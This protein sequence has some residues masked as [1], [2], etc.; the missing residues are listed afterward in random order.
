MVGNGVAERAILILL[1]RFYCLRTALNY[2]ILSSTVL[3]CT[4]LY[5]TA[6]NCSALL[7]QL[8]S[9]LPCF[10]PAGVI[11]ISPTGA[12]SGLFRLALLHKVAPRQP[13]EAHVGEK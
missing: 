10:S 7:S 3:Y 13:N 2:N 6:P 4:A 12:V 11:V 8:Y 5:Y 9:S 1:K